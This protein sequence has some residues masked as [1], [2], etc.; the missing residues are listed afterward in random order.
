MY[1]CIRCISACGIV[2]LHQSF[3]ILGPALLCSQNDHFG[4]KQ[5]LSSCV[6]FL[7]HTVAT[8][9][10]TITAITTL[11]K[12]RYTSARWGEWRWNIR[13]EWETLGRMSVHMSASFH[14][15][16]SEK[17]SHLCG[18][19]HYAPQDTFSST[20]S[21]PHTLKHMFHYQLSMETCWYTHIQRIFF[22]LTQHPHKQYQKAEFQ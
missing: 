11:T 19:F 6:K 4:E 21:R 16:Q 5:K 12:C 18:H 22:Y 8:L 13:V 7:E 17:Y 2:L 20:L 3:R 1:S 15:L 14:E 10:I 9:V